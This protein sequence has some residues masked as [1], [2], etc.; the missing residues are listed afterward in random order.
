MSDTNF[1]NEAPDVE[2]AIPTTTNG[3]STSGGGGVSFTNTGESGEPHPESSTERSKYGNK[4]L[5]A[6][7][8]K[9][10]MDGDGELDEA[11]QAMRD[12]DKSGRGFLKNEEVY[13]MMKDQLQMQKDLFKMKKVIAGLMVFV[14]ILALSNLGT[15]FAS[16]ILAKD[17]T[18][19]D[20]NELVSKETGEA[21]ATQSTTK[22]FVVDPEK[23]KELSHRHRLLCETQGQ[24]NTVNSAT[25][26]VGNLQSII[27]AD[28]E[29]IAQYCH[30]SASVTIGHIDNGQEVQ[31]RWCPITSNQVV[32]YSN[33]VNKNNGSP[34]TAGANK[35]VPREMTITDNGS[36]EIHRLTR[37]PARHDGDDP[38]YTL[39]TD[40]VGCQTEVV[41][42][43]GTIEQDGDCVAIG[44][45]T[46][47]VSCED[48]AEPVCGSDGTKYPCA[49][50]V[51]PQLALAAS[52]TPCECG[53]F[54][55]MDP[56]Q[57]CVTEYCMVSMCSQQVF[58]CS[59]CTSATRDNCCATTCRN[60][61]SRLD[62]PH[63][64]CERRL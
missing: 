52:P 37:H 55:G 56:S 26:N 25:C 38:Y 62:S 59:D 23:D 10:D 47:V 7:S 12:M 27:E 41:C 30:A 58:F 19:N 24:G 44:G 54:S 39:T 16:A 18:T 34:S 6:A 51:P 32:A 15:S 13:G 9:Y 63:D 45:Q 42:P 2:E 64:G 46:E 49:A 3:S 22:L 28:G 61:S 14:V 29:D 4:R 60:G 50:A 57:D 33:W 17:S 53:G 1:T 5:S 48:G 21:L 8:K 11:E 36:S 20:Q 35:A 31:R 40:V 43:D